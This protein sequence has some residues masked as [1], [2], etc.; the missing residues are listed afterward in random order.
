MRGPAGLVDGLLQLMLVSILRL[1]FGL[2]ASLR[3]GIVRIDAWGRLLAAVFTTVLKVESVEGIVCRGACGRLLRWLR[4]AVGADCRLVALLLHVLG[5]IF[6]LIKRAWLCVIIR[7]S[8]VRGCL[9]LVFGAAC[10]VVVVGYP[11]S[12]QPAFRTTEPVADQPGNLR[13]PWSQGSSD[14]YRSVS[15]VQCW[16][17]L[18]AENVCTNSH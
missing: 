2:I 9:L 13:Q 6:R 4:P 16:V 18:H 12:C 3:R 5:L 1:V 10:D 7:I 8:P 15:L 17:W 11:D 14:G